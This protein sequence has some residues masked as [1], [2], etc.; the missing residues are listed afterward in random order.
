MLQT[1]GG[2]G[3]YSGLQNVHIDGCSNND[4]DRRTEQDAGQM[5]ELEMSDSLQTVVAM[6]CNSQHQSDK[7]SDGPRE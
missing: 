3:S 2:R 7:L 6:Q 5:K 1:V 4:N